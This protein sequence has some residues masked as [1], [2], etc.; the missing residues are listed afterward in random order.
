MKERD[1]FLISL[2]YQKGMGKI[3]VSSFIPGY[4]RFS[5]SLQTIEKG[6]PKKFKSRLNKSYLINALCKRYGEFLA[7]LGQMR[8]TT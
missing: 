6:R 2:P 7:A 4:L 8:M 5:K 3:H 1:L